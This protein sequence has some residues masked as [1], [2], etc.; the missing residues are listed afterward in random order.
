MVRAATI[1][2][3]DSR[4]GSEEEEEEE[5][6]GEEFSAA[7]ASV[8]PD[9]LLNEQEDIRSWLDGIKQGWAARFASAFE[10]VGVEDTSDL[11]GFGGQAAV[12][13][14]KELSEHGAKSLHVQRI[15]DAIAATTKDARA[16]Q[17]RLE[18]LSGIGTAGSSCT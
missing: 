8:V 16:T 5:A 15:T 6:T 7:R 13:L 4:S 10:A 9:N 1:R 17:A 18:G 3:R 2:A 12:E 11:V 14:M